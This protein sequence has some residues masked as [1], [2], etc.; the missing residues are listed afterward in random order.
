MAK[1]SILVPLANLVTIIQILLKMTLHLI[2][3]SR[4][5]FIF[6]SVYFIRGH[7][8]RLTVAVL[9]LKI[10]ANA[11]PMPSNWTTL[12]NASF[13]YFAYFMIYLR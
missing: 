4:M 12:C 11:N 5:R 13:V 9:A 1:E 6:Y 7:F 3:S 10:K 8:S 2:N